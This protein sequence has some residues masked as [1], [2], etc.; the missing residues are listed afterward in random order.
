MQREK[1][2]RLEICLSISRKM[3]KKETLWELLKRLD[4]Q[5]GQYNAYLHEANCY[6]DNSA[7]STKKILNDH[8]KDLHKLI[9]KVRKALRSF[10]K[11]KKNNK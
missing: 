2:T 6:F 4:E 10:T 3:K 7:M 1:R 11:Q 5:A 8:E 9:S